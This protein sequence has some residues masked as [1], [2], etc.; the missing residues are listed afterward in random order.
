[1]TPLTKNS[2]IP[3]L[4]LCKVLIIG[5]FTPVFAQNETQKTV[6]VNDNSVENIIKYNARDSIYSDLKSKKIHLYGDAKFESEEMKM[7][8]GYIL[9]DLEKEEITARYALDKE[10][11]KVELPSFTDGTENVVCE[12]IRY[13]LKTKKGY[14]EELATKQDEFYFQM[15]IAK[16][17]PNEEIHLRQGKITTCNLEEPHYHF[18]LKKGVVI[19][20]QRIV[21]GP[22][23]L[24]VAGLPTPFGLPFAILPTNQKTRKSGL[25][26]PE[27][28]PIS[29]YGFGFQN[30]GY[31]IPINDNFQT[32]VYANLYSRG[33]WGLRNDLDYAKR[34]GFSG[35]IS[36]GFQQFRAGF[37][38][39]TKQNKITISWTHRK[40]PKS[41]PYWNF[42]SNV[43]FISDNN[44]KN[45]LDPLNTQYF[46]NSF[47][48]DINLNRLFPGKPITTGMK[49]SMRQNS[50]AKDIALTSPI[51]NVNVTRIFPFKR[52]FKVTDKEWKKTLERVGI[53]YNMEAQNRSRFADSLLT[54]G[55]FGGMGQQFMNGIS[56]SAT[57]QTSFGLFK[58]TVKINP[59]AGYGNKINFQQINKSYDAVSNKTVVDTLAKIGMAHEF[60]LN[61]TASTV[62]YSYYQVVGKNKPK[63]RH[64]LTPTVGYRYVPLLNPLTTALVGPNQTQV[65]YSQYEKSIYSVGN[66]ASASFLTFGINNTL[67]LK[68]KSEKDTVTGFKKVRLI[69]QFSITGD[70]NFKKD[71]MRLSNINLNVR[72]SPRDFLNFVAT[73]TFSPYAYDSTGK[74]LSAY[75][76]TAQQ[77][78]GRMMNV[79]FTTSLLI[80]PKKDRKK[81]EE[82]VGAFNN[83]K[84][85]NDFNYYALHP[86]RAIY[87]DI[88]WKMNLSH[89]YTISANTNK[90]VSNPDL[91]IFIQTLVVNGDI[92]FTKRWNL[93][94]NMN[95]NVQTGKVT[96]L[97]IALN[98]NL[99]CWALS[100]YWIPLGGNKS[101]LLSIRNTSS[102]FRD[103][104]FD[105]RK[106]PS[107]L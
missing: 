1:M 70:Y 9:I 96:N 95:V 69:D 75:A 94:G 50:V 39:D 89:V 21:A 105:I 106:P 33:S 3:L 103:A 64:L 88:P 36:A 63:L 4:F 37:P 7:S 55:D 107:F 101:F 81:I 68:F 85:N 28:V 44:S 80:A 42:S 34:Y 29:Q 73:G 74:S 16:R 19:P 98:R 31:Y 17:Q 43:N 20:N 49:I 35:R 48:S 102:I 97:N 41:N 82:S 18:Q 58:N 40:E 46:N 6:Y 11:N 47:N 93:S 72:V 26:F 2:A 30:L 91:Y 23:N 92:S 25:L 79:S 61:V 52:L 87:F 15:G 57:L 78:L 5:L 53:S 66:T 14:M 77:G 22:M 67:E 54:Q 99:H 83:E 8:A 62:V 24:W 65:I 12:T 13:N 100:F 71:S 45:N 104:K 38:S 59:S 76:I 90:T 56:Q 10:G 32:S 60:N 86:E 84:W 27:M 51:F